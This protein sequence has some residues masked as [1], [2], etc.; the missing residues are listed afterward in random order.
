MKNFAL[1]LALIAVVFTTAAFAQ[2]EPK[3]RIQRIV[4]LGIGQGTDQEPSTARDEAENKTIEDAADNAFRRCSPEYDETLAGI[5]VQMPDGSL[6]NLIIQVSDALVVF[7]VDMHAPSC[8]KRGQSYSCSMTL[9]AA[10]VFKKKTT[11]E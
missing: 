1:K 9:H 7:N 10:C 11:N 8:T 6:S 3:P 4:V 2:T 5:I